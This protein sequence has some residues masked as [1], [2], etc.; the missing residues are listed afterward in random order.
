MPPVGAIASGSAVSRPKRETFVSTCDTSTSTFGSRRIRSKAAR[1]SRRV[2]SSSAPPSKKSKIAR[3]KRRCARRRRS[4]IFTAR[5]RSAIGQTE[6]HLG[7]LVR[8]SP[9]REDVDLEVAG[10]AV[11]L[12]EPGA[13][14]ASHERPFG[15]AGLVGKE[16]LP[17]ARN[18]GAPAP[19]H[20][21]N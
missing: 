19:E 6:K 2:T 13:L 12:G 14:D 4:A 9:E 8:D 15:E 7:V 18:L 5:A 3:G 10:R 21:E 11:G 17:A 16:F 20:V 1:F